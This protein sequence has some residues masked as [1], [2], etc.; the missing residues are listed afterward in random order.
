MININFEMNKYIDTYT[1]T[2]EYLAPTLKEATDYM[3]HIYLSEIYD[4]SEIDE[5]LIDAMV[6]KNLSN[7]ELK[8][9]Y[10]KFDRDTKTY[11]EWAQYIID[12][13]NRFIKDDIELEFCVLNEK[14]KVFQLIVIGN[15]DWYKID[16]VSPKYNIDINF[17]YI[18]IAEDFNI[19]FEEAVKLVQY[20]IDTINKW[21]QTVAMIR[22]WQKNEYHLQFKFSNIFI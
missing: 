17:G 2:P 22:G 12:E 5:D 9:F 15:L 4:D 11:D 21:L 13:D 10:S 16:A 8:E 14:L 1:C 3:I 7:S 6:F 18:E 19:S 20:E